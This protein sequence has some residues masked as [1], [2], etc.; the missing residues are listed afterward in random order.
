MPEAPEVSN[1]GSE[2]GR[3]LGQ[4]E[5]HVAPEHLNALMTSIEVGHLK[6][7]MF[8]QEW[9]TE[10]EHD[11]AVQEKI[12][13]TFTDLLDQLTK[14]KLSVPGQLEGQLKLV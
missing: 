9:A 12:L 7:N 6:H 4:L 3:L 13:E 14:R 2:I 8:H 11:R 5:K 1:I 10:Q